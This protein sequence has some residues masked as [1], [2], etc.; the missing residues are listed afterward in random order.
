VKSVENYT[1]PNTG[2]LI[3]RGFMN[4]VQGGYELTRES[5]MDDSI[6]IKLATKNELLKNEV[7]SAISRALTPYRCVMED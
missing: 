3:I 4:R 6:V 5:S 2:H 1:R 7:V